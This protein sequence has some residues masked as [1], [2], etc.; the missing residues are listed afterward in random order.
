VVAL[1]GA[2]G[3]GKSTIAALL[4]RIYDPT[5]GAI[6]IDQRDIRS[7]DAKWLRFGLKYFYLIFFVSLNENLS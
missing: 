4:A 3:N 7:L 6:K 5:S 2:S 1:V